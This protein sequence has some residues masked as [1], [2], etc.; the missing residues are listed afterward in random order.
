[1]PCESSGRFLWATRYF[2]HGLNGILQFARIVLCA[3]KGAMA[4]VA[5]IVD[6]I[7]NCAEFC[8]K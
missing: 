3:G 5:T 1:M 8:R 6:R 4:E 2:H 7:M